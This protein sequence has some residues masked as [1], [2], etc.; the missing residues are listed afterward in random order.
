[1]E[2][3][4]GEYFDDCKP[5]RSSQESYNESYAARLWD[6]SLKITHTL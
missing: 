1:V 6:L 3:V 4:S 2:G 5:T